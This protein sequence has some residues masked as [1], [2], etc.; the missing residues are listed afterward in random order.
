MSARRA[1]TSSHAGG[2]LAE[3]VD[4]APQPVL[5]RDARLEAD[6]LACPRDVEVAR[7]L[8]VRAR[9]VPHDRAVEAR[10]AADELG[11]LADP[12]LPAHA[13]VDGIGDVEPL[14]RQQQAAR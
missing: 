9:R 10:E 12:R 13:E 7:R 1:D 14:G 2:L 11:E 8:A 6:E 4:R 5:E 3:R